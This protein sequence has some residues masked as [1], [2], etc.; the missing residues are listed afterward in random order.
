[1][2]VFSLSLPLLSLL[3]LSSLSLSSLS[4]L[5]PLQAASSFLAI[6][7]LVAIIGCPYFGWFVDQHGRALVFI[8]VAAGMLVITHVGFLGNAIGV[9]Q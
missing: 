5:S 6:P 1:M 3:S 7:N 4:P 9:H 2:Y 8:I